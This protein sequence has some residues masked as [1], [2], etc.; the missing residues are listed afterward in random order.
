M[1]LEK[2]LVQLEHEKRQEELAFWKDTA[3]VRK[4]LFAQAF[5]YTATRRRSQLLGSLEAQYG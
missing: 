5:E 1:N 2:L 4:D 3:E